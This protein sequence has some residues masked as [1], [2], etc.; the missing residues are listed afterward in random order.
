MPRKPLDLS[1]QT[2]GSLLVLRRTDNNK[3][4]QAMW[5]CRCTMPSC[6]KETVKPATMLRRGVKTCG[7]GQYDRLRNEQ[8]ADI[9]GIVFGRL[10]AVR[11]QGFTGK[12]KTRRTLWLCACSCE[13][14]KTCLA[15]VA[16][17]RTGKVSSCGCLRRE[18]VRAVAANNAKRHDLFGA[19]VTAAEIGALVCATGKL[20]SIWLHGGMTAEEIVRRKHPF[21]LGPQ[22]GQ[23]RKRPT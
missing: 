15:S 12:R 6:G 5:L 21:H 9:A 7:C 2:I 10:T 11:R 17:L 8:F 14:G 4:G 1:G 16:D 18:S 22:P 13:A 19:L 23:R 3:H 20:V